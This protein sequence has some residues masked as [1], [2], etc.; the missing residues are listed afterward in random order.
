MS[1][2]DVTFDEAREQMRSRA[3]LPGAEAVPLDALPGRRLARDLRARVDNPAF[4]N[5]AMD[6]FA[7]RAADAAAGG[8]LRVVGESRAGAP[9]ATTLCAG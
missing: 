7:V 2:R 6:G 4:T 1:L 5:S 8:G 9:F 3:P